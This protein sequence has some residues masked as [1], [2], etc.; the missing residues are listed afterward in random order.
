[1]SLHNKAINELAPADYL[2]I[3]EEHRLLD[4]YLSD[5]HD[6]CACSK[7]DQLPDCQNCDHEKQASCQGRLPSF[8]FHIID[9]AGRHFEHE[10][11]IMLSRPHVTIAYEYYRVHKQAHADIM[12]QLY[13]LS[14]ECLSLRNQGN[15]A[16]I[17]NRFHEK[18]SHLFAEHDRSFDDPFIQSTKP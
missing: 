18:L 13:A 8:L 7:L 6:A 3:Q 17:F 2:V 5:L 9:L 16:Q 4:K 10:E 14:D 1:M 12:Q 11:I 15:T